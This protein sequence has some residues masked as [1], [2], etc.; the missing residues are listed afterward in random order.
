M[1]TF[2]DF[3]A[4]LKATKTKYLHFEEAS[5][6]QAVKPFR[7]FFQQDVNFDDKTLHICTQSRLTRHLGR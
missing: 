1:Y 7:H 5:T 6:L 3:F 2:G 4:K